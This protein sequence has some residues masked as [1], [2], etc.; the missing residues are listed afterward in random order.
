MPKVTKFQYHMSKDCIKIMDLMIRRQKLKWDNCLI[1]DGPEGV[2]KSTFV[3]TLGAY[4]AEKMDCQF[5]VD[6]V[7][8]DPDE[9]VEFA[10]KTRNQII[11]WDEAAFSGLGKQWQSKIQQKL[12]TIMMTARKYGHFWI[13]VIPS[14][15]ELTKYLAVHR[16]TFLFHLYTPDMVSRGLYNI[17]DQ[18][19]KSW[20]YNNNKKSMTYG[21][22][23]AGDGTYSLKN[24]HDIIDE[25][26]YEQ[27]KDDAI[28]KYA[29]N[30]PKVKDKREE[31]LRKI[32][33]NCASTLPAELSEILLEC[34]KG[35]V[36][37]FKKFGAK[38][39]WEPPYLRKLRFTVCEETRL[40]WKPQKHKRGVERISR[41]EVENEPSADAAI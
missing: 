41:Q 6:N 20:I 1:I 40:P 33:F 7:F 24:T 28:I 23:K 16:S 30:D 13:F 31:K 15:W 37:D 4:Y 12:L 22:D 5:T 34:A 14:F 2:G 39:G 17:Y 36:S 21:T 26:A 8:F 25:E 18:R 35:T 29:I 27:K 3:K 10:A 38:R 32:Q 9:L 19:Q 11:W